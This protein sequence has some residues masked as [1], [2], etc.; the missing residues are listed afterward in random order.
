MN[1]MAT[2]LDVNDNPN[3]RYVHNKEDIP[4]PPPLEHKHQECPDLQ[5]GNVHMAGR[6]QP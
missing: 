2:A 4:P 1:K 6:N 5:Y 3:D